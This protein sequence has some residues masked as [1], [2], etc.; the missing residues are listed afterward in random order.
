MFP[1]LLRRVNFTFGRQKETPGHPGYPDGLPSHPKR[2]LPIITPNR[3]ISQALCC[4]RCRPR[5]PKTRRQ[6]PPLRTRQP[7]LP[8]SRAT[9]SP[10]CHLTRR[11]SPPLR[12]CQPD[13][14][15]Y[16]ATCSPQCHL[17]C[18]RICRLRCRPEGPKTRRQSPP[19]R[20]RQPDLAISR[21]TCSPQCHLTCPRICRR[22]ISPGT[23]PLGRPL[24]LMF[25]IGH[26]PTTLF[27]QKIYL[28]ER[29]VSN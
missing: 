25:R 7:D 27:G 13:L 6:G 11:Q 24:V 3:A 20:T 5:G 16:R 8:V 12:T 22:R 28:Q 10:Q 17:T 18:T 29:I 15:V 14:P 23:H 19:P 1:P 21:A 4:L 26:N 2:T 9:Y